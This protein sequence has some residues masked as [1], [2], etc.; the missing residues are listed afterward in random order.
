M[1]NKLDNVLIGGESELP[2]DFEQAMAQ[3]ISKLTEIKNIEL[4]TELSH[5]E[6]KL[7]TAIKIVGERLNDSI[8]KEVFTWYPKLMVSKNRKGREEIAGIARAIKE[9]ISNRGKLSKLKEWI[10]I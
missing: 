5:D 7:L 9:E 4:L 8:K 1:S 2:E 6:I 10:G 3:S